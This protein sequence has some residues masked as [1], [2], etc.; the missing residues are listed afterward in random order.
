[1]CHVI[2]IE[3]NLSNADTCGTEVF[4]RFREVSALVRFELKSSQI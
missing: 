3:W 4:I 1:M 2:D